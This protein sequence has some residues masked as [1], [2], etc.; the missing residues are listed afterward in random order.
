MVGFY[1]TEDHAKAINDF[2]LFL[3]DN[4]IKVFS[5]NEKVSFRTAKHAYDIISKGSIGKV[6]RERKPDLFIISHAEEFG[7][8]FVTNN[9]R[10]YKNLKLKIPI[11]SPKEFLDVYL[12]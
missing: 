5:F 8:V 4:N 1:F 11:L 6:Y 9:K 2:M 3:E 12:M 10:H 7:D